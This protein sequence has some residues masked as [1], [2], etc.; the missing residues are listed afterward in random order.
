MSVRDFG[1]GSAFLRR[2]GDFGF[3]YRG[4]LIPFILATLLVVTRPS[5]ALRADAVARGVTFTGIA[6]ALMG[7][8][9]RFFVIGFAYIKRGGKNRRIYADDLVTE[10]VYAHVRNPMYIGNFLILV[11]LAIL[12][13]SPL[14][15]AIGVPLVGLLYF[16]IVVSEEAYLR[17]KFGAAY[18]AY[19]R[20][21]NRFVPRLAGLRDTVQGSHYDWRKALRKE[22]GTPHGL[23]W[24]LLLL[25]L[26]R[27]LRLEGFSG[28][29]QLFLICAAI[30]IP[31]TL[32]YLVV[33]RWKMAGGLASRSVDT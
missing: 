14:A 11:G 19:V 18:D 21:V 20:D 4:L 5:E 25:I 13:G 33:R 9:I 24:G 15:F 16:A 32:L 26:F 23:G 2:A 29:Q 12:W 28:Q 8:A 7:Q 22:Y 31:W 6:I 10:G 30:G 17:E 3:H 1:A 27:T